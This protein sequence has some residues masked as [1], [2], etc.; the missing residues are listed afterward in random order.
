M[1][2]E[3]IS[4]TAPSA[5]GEQVDD[6]DSLGKLFGGDEESLREIFKTFLE[7]APK[8][9]AGIRL[10]CKNKNWTAAGRK[11]HQAKPFF[12]YAG[13]DETVQLLE[14]LQ[15]EW[16]KATPAHDFES[17]LRALEAKTEMLVEKLKDRLGRKV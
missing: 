10:D 16:E 15:R 6:F 5:K 12:G 7:E 2:D 1:L 17:E 14:T 4:A 11:A 13:D 3:Q 8:N 9:L